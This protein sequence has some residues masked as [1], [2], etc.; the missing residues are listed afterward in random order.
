MG[1][2]DRDPLNHPHVVS[3]LLGIC[4]G[5]GETQTLVGRCSSWCFWEA[6]KNG[7]FTI[8]RVRTWEDAGNMLSLE[9]VGLHRTGSLDL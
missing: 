6:V 2:A 7:I 4:P 1:G 5:E 3:F 8:E 9:D